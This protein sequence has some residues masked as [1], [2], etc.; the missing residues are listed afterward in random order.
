MMASWDGEWTGDMTMWMDPKVEPTKTTGTCVN[1]MIMGGRYQSSTHTASFNGMPFEG[2]STL[3]YDNAKKKFISSWIDN[4][5]TGIMV[6]EGT[7][8]PATKTLNL[9]GSCTDPMTGK[10]IAVRETFSLID[11]NT[12][13]MEMYMTPAGQKE[14]KSMEIV[15]KRK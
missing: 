8:D 4:M 14:Y 12:Q 5:G 1:K 7:W 13:K 15:F 3:A 2:N 6:M 11:N 9:T 10:D